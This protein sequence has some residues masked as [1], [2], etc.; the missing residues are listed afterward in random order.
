MLNEVAIA[1]MESNLQTFALRVREFEA[2][3]AT[4][5]HRRSSLQAIRQAAVTPSAGASLTPREVEILRLVA[6]GKDNVE[7]AERLHYSLG[8]IKL[9]MREILRKTGTSTRAE[10]AV[11]ASRSGLI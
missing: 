2:A 11:H 3:L 5:R 6:A 10:A 8:T 1:R 9:H 7:I 4:F